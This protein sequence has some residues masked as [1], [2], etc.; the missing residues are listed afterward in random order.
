MVLERRESS[1]T[2]GEVQMNL[3]PGRQSFF[4]PGR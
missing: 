1:D 2:H 4:L 3:V